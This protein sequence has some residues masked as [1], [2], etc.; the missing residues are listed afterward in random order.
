M[1]D[2]LAIAAHPGEIERTCGGTLVKMARAGYK[3]GVI[4]LTDGGMGTH[5]SPETNVEQ[6]D[7]AGKIL[8]LA[9]RENLHFPDARLENTM[10]ARMTLAQR[11]RDLGPRTVILPYWQSEHPD[12]VRASELAAESCFLAGLAQLDQYTEPCKVEK[13]LY[14]SNLSHAQPSLLTDISAEFETR[15]EALR[16]YIHQSGSESLAVRA[17]YYGQM[18]GVQYAE[19]FIIKGPIRVD[20]VAGW[21]SNAR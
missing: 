13:I 14:A 3:T 1:L 18:I 17:S 15:M 20:N 8:L 4:D 2:I 21:F 11:I 5:G 10:P 7:A 9:H 16:L 19:P 12:H 6:A